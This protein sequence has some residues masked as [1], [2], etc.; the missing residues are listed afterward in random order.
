MLKISL[1]KPTYS[2]GGTITAVIALSLDKPTKARGIFARLFC[3]ERNM[4]KLSKVM[5]QYDLDRAAELGT[6][7]SGTIKWREEERDSVFYDQEKKISNEGDYSSGIFVAR[8]ALPA[9]APPTSREFGHD[10]KIT[11]WKLSA[12]L[13]I[14]LAPDTSHAVEVFVE[15]I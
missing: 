6:P 12:K 4:V 8:F 2:P 7:Y 14:P 15:G 10:N 1:D 11:E 5:D 9:N 3:T 13:D